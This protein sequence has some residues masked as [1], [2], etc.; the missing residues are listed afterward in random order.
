MLQELDTRIEERRQAKLARWLEHWRM[1]EPPIRQSRLAYRLAAS[2][3]LTGIVINV[4][5]AL[6]GGGAVVAWELNAIVI[7]L[8]LAIGLLRLSARV[9]IW[10]LLRA[11]LGGI[12]LPIVALLYNEVAVALLIAMAKWGYSGALLLLLTGESKPWR[13]VLASAL[14]VVF[15]VGIYSLA[16]FF[17]A[18]TYLQGA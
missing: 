18:F 10:T 16:L 1:K 5:D 17:M 14:F 9:R 12:A 8:I 13:L 6:T 2:V 15:T 3:L 4:V 7:D 11:V